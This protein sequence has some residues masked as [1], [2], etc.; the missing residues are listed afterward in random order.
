LQPR[1]C[2][3]RDFKLKNAVSRL[4]EVWFVS[5]CIE[6]GDLVVDAQVDDTWAHE[7]IPPAA[8]SPEPLK[9]MQARK[10]ALDMAIDCRSN[11]A[12]ED[13]YDLEEVADQN[14]A[15][16]KMLARRGIP[17]ND[18]PANPG[19]GASGDQQGT[20]DGQQQQQQ[21]QQGD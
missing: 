19:P 13:G 9:D 16:R 6:N 18:A 12:M 8:P 21:G 10:L 11:F 3:N 5:L 17:L 14:E 4:V 15:D 7:W 20:G 1:R 2:A